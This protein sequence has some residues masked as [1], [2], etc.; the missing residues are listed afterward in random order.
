MHQP[1]RLG[2]LSVFLLATVAL[3]PRTQAA[4]DEAIIRQFQEDIRAEL[5]R[6]AISGVSVALVDDQ[7][8]LFAGGFGF[9][10]KKRRVPAVRDTVYRAGSISK[11]FTALAVMQLSEQGRL[12]IDAPVTEYLP[13]LGIVSPFEDA[14]PMTLRQLMCHRSGMVR[15]APVG[16]YLDDAQAGTAKTVASLSG[17]ALVYPPNTRTKYSNSGVTIAGY[18]VERVSAQA[19]QE[20]Q[21]RH[22]LG[23]MGMGSSSFVKNSALRRRLAKGYLPV[24]DG[25]GGFREIEAPAFELGTIPAGNLYTTAEDLARFLSFLFAEG[26]AGGRQMIQRPTLTEMFTPQLTKET[27]GFGLGFSVG[28]VRGHKTV[29]HMG[30]VYGFTSMVIGVPRHK[31][32]VV[33]LCNDDIVTAAVRRLALN[34][35]GAMLEAKTGE[36]TPVKPRIDLAA[37]DLAAF[38]GEYESESWWAEVKAAA[39]GLEMNV[40]GQ[41]LTLTPVEPLQFE[42]NGRLAWDAPVTFVRDA[43]GKVTGFSAL[44]QKFRRVVHPVA[45][46]IPPDWKKF[47][48][49]YGPDFIPLIITARHG[50]LYAMVE[51]EYD[52]RLTPLNRTVF[53]MPPGMY[54]DEQ[55]VFQTDARGRVHTAVLANMPLERH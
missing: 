1:F 31:L 8:T 30:A 28:S 13:A 39:R 24:A 21:R 38:V 16:G 2:V 51:N 46:P 50:H 44:G 29:S 12:K 42:A 40:S 6:G 11:L 33:V 4:D 55:L 47:L 26:N 7:R 32:G 9:A 49:V 45:A 5:E 34:A 15:E 17:C 22:L 43:A 52:N 35:L 25:H 48:G 3:S 19:F 10:D 36:T 18:I 20:Y 23:P 53:K 54:V 27:N 41:R 14:A 37:A